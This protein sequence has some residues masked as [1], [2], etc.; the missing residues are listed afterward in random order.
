MTD[1]QVMSFSLPRPA[2]LRPAST[3]KRLWQGGL[4]LAAITLTFAIGNAFLPADRS[5]TPGMLGHD[6]LAFYT[7]GTFVRTGQLDKLYDLDATRAFQR[8]EAA[9]SGL[10]IGP[11]F[12]P[13]WNPPFYAWVFAPLSALPYRTALAVWTMFGVAALAAS[14]WLLRR[15]LVGADSRHW[16]HGAVPTPHDWRST[17][18]VPLLLLVCMPFV[19]AISH[20]QNTFCSL[21]L[22]TGVVVLWR[23]RR[24][25][26]AGLVCGLLFYKP[27]LAAC[28]AG[29]L[30]LT[31]GRRALL[32]LAVSVGAL[33]AVTLL[34][35]PGIVGEYLTRLPQNLHFMQIDNPYLWERHATLK[36]FWRLLIQGRDPGEM[37]TV[38]RAAWLASAGL[39]ACGL[40]R[41]VWRQRDVVL[42]DPWSGETRAVRLDRVIAATIA[43][44]PLLMPFYFDYDLLL[45]S[46]P[47]TLLAGELLNRPSGAERPACDRWLVRAWVALYAWTLVN[48][49]MTNLLGV[50]G[51]VLLLSAVAALSTAR[52]AREPA[53]L[54]VVET[55][56]VQRTPVRR[57]A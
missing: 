13:F 17:L 22:L 2:L 21:L 43:S 25:L 35:M 36:A 14:V 42:D 55:V 52:A 7:G 45:L 39:L 44:A 19:Q 26:P 56:Q 27:Q 49:G 50:N 31:L 37:W 28:V 23:Q 51:N 41:M 12:G 10:E 1:N 33:G 54:P 30:V 32:G 18:L 46:I 3:R 53:A 48:P 20:A 47:A 57:A 16:F 9:R 34:T 6:F 24:A 40:A 4:A 15:L 38:T 29:M 5:V 8:A 11:S